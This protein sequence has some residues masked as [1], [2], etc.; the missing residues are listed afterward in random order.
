[1]ARTEPMA[2]AGTKMKPAHRGRGFA[3]A[4][5]SAVAPPAATAQ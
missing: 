4:A 5:M 1:M 3:V 2:T